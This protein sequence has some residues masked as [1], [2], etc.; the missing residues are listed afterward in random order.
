MNARPTLPHLS[1]ITTIVAAAVS[2][3]IAIGLLAAV[4]GL[5]QHDGTPFGQWV[6]AERACGSYRFVSERDACMSLYLA[7]THVHDIARR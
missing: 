4:S 2:A 7:A 5:F 3:V 6:A 1:A